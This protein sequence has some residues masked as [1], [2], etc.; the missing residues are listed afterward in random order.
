MDRPVMMPVLFENETDD[1]P[2]PRTSTTLRLARLVTRFFCARFLRIKKRTR[3][4]WMRAIGYRRAFAPV[5]LALICAVSVF[6]VT[7]PPSAPVSMNPLSCGLF[8]ESVD[9]PSGQSHLAGWLVPV[10]DAQRVLQEREHLYKEKY[11]AVVLAHDFGKSSQQLLNLIRPLHEKQMV[12][13]ALEQRGS[14]END[15]RG[16]TFGLAESADLAAAVGM[17]RARPDVDPKKI[18]IVGVGSGANAALHAT[19]LDPMIAALVIEQPFDGFE[20]AF[21]RQVRGSFARRCLPTLHPVLR[22]TFELM[23]GV[24]AEDLRPATYRETLEKMAVMM[25]M[26]PLEPEKSVAFLV[27]HLR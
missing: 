24:D 19:R 9:L 16:Q 18:A 11:P 15:L 13:L 2:P 10:V 17:L 26:T 3:R 22:W 4:E 6:C 5:L 25:S 1:A 14:G 27:Q 8:F 23:Y 12:V 7:H 21:D 20:D